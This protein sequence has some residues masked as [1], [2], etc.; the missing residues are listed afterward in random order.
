MAPSSPSQN[1]LAPSPL[2]AKR[3]AMNDSMSDAERTEAS[4]VLMCDRETSTVCY[5]GGVKLW[6]APDHTTCILCS[7]ASMCVRTVYDVC[8]L[9]VS[10]LQGGL[11]H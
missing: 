1:T 2:E 8:V 11:A 5:A 3:G 9:F 4:H 10:T 7:I 6:V